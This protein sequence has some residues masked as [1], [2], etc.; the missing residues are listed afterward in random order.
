VGPERDGIV[1]RGVEPA[2]LLKIGA[3]RLQR[4]LETLVVLKI[5]SRKKEGFLGLS[6][7]SA[8]TNRPAAAPSFSRFLPAASADSFSFGYSAPWSTAPFT[9]LKPQNSIVSLRYL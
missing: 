1:I 9:G 6:L 4:V 5:M 7:F 3:V 2:A 8:S